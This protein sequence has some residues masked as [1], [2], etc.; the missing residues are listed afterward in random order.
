MKYL[1]SGQPVCNFGLAMNESY[2][3]RT[4]GEKKEI[5]TFVDC[6]AW[7]KTAENITEYLAK[8]SPIFIEGSLKF[9]QWEHADGT[10]RSRLKVRV[11]RFQFVGSKQDEQ[12]PTDDTQDPPHQS[13][14]PTDNTSTDD[15]IPF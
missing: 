13:D 10:K 9:E 7:D 3:D 14:P 6:E 8:G 11:M 1:T 4:T 15:D 12:T 2:T 5:A